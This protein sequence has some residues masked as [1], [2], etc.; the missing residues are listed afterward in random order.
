MIY[1]VHQSIDGSWHAVTRI[2]GCTSLHSIGQSACKR[3][4]ESMAHEANMEAACA[5]RRA[6]LYQLKETT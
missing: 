2:E 3:A 5:A 4:A 6:R 1:F